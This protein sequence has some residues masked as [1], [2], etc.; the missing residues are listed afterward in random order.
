ML[1]LEE[2]R[3]LVERG[4]IDTVI[5]ALTDMQGRL[6]VKRLHGEVF[7]EEAESGHEC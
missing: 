3:D 4:E 2:L 6:L 1:S 5:A 7:V